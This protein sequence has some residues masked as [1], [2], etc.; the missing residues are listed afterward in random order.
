MTVS[1]NHHVHTGLTVPFQSQIGIPLGWFYLMSQEYAVILQLQGFLG[2]IE[3]GGRIA[4][5]VSPNRSD[6]G[7]AL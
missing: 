3:R 1:V 5:N 7:N 6:R 4:V 2:R